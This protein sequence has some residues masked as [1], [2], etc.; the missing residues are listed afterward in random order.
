RAHRRRLF[1]K[2]RKNQEGRGNLPRRQSLSESQVYRRDGRR[3]PLRRFQYVRHG[4]KNRRERLFAFVLAS[5]VRRGEGEL[6]ESCDLLFAVTP[7]RCR[8]SR[9]IS[10]RETPDN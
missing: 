8:G 3:A 10:K 9:P 6:N 1:Q 7:S 2:S 5:Q 4:F